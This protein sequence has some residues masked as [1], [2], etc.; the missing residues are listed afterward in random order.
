LI[1]DPLKTTFIVPNRHSEAVLM[2]E[3]KK[4]TENG[5]LVQNI[6]YWHIIVLEDLGFDIPWDD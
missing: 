4:M 6:N 5:E 2:Q 1:L 3:V